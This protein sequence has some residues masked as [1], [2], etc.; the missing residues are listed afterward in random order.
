VPGAGAAIRTNS[1]RTNDPANS[2][3]AMANAVAR[4]PI[5]MARPASGGPAVLPSRTT[6]ARIPCARTSWSGRV[7]SGGSAPTA[8][9]NSA[10][11]EPKASATV[12]ST[13]RPGE[14]TTRLTA[15]PM[16]TRQRTA[17]LPMTTR[18]GPNRS[19]TTPPPS[20]STARGT[21]PSAN[22]SP[23]W[24]GPPIWLA[25]QPRARK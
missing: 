4:P 17:S 10:S 6:S 23:T 14:V 13:H 15:R 5:P 9:R 16:I 11:T 20:I 1:R 18:R 24:E 2:P 3:P 21:A 12:T 19:A 7:I 25:A 8:G 22:T